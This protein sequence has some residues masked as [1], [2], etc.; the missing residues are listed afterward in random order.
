MRKNSALLPAII[1]LALAACFF[2]FQITYN[3]TDSMW[4]ETVD[5]MI[6]TDTT[7]ISDD[8]SS[9]KQA[10]SGGYLYEVNEN[11][12]VDGIMK[13][14]VSGL[15][16]KYAMYLNSKQYTD[17]IKTTTASTQVGI[18][19][20]LLYDSTLDGLYVVNVY[21]NSP[22][23]DAGMV[24]GDIITHI[25]GTSV[26]TYGFYGSLLELGYGNED[27]RI[28]VIFKKKNGENVSTFINKRV[29]KAESIK[30]KR[31][32]NSI[33]L[34]SVSSFE[35]DGKEKFVSA[36]ESLIASGCEKFV[37]DI[38]NNCGGSIEEAT[39]ILDFLLP[40]GTLVAVTDRTGTTNTIDSDVN[41]SPY[42]VA[43][44]I[45]KGTVCE[46]EVFAAAMKN[47]GKAKLVG[48]V[49]YG[50]ASKQSLFTLPDGGAVC[51]STSAYILSGGESFDSTGISPDMTVNLSDDV[52][53]NF[54][55]IDDSRDAQLQQAINYLKE[56]KAQNITY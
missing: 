10:V 9:L 29:V 4:R 38:R 30:S 20:N 54:T 3:V 41:E 14:Y 24:P 13:G 27:D 39:S 16:D 2:T 46:A 51:F 42:P 35:A 28:A 36:M 33:G 8:L 19:V 11:N 6:R 43:V 49:T 12:L 31:L 26:K 23:K 53:M 37:I 47:L 1:F 44:L 32:G 55:S 22:A 17:Y 56:I 5:E 40:S 15:G 45:N 50:K 52:I 18:G 34:I 25:N 21:D 7:R 48:N